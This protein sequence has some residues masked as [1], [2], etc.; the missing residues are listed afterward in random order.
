MIQIVTIENPFQPEFKNVKYVEYQ[1]GLFITDY[2]PEGAEDGAYAVNGAVIKEPAGFI[3][4]DNC[5]IVVTPH[6]AGG[7]F[8]KIFG[9]IAMVALS[10]YAG[11]VAG[12]LWSSL[13]SSFAAGGTGAMLAS[14]AIMLVGGL[15]ISSIMPKAQVPSLD[16]KDHETSQTYGWDIPTPTQAEGNIIGETYGE[17]IPKPQILTQHVETEGN[18]QYL[19]LLLCGGMGP[20]DEIS[21]IRIGNNDIANY[22]GV[23]IE[24]RLGENDQEPISFFNNTPIDHQVNLELGDYAITQTTQSKKANKIEITMS[25]P[26]GLYRL[27]DDGNYA[28]TT[29]TFS[30]LYRKHGTTAWIGANK[31]VSTSGT[32]SVSYS[33]EY[34]TRTKTYDSIRE[35]SF[36][37][38]APAETWTVTPIAHT[39]QV[40]YVVWSGRTRYRTE[41]YYT[42]SVRGSLSGTTDE[43][44]G[45]GVLYDNGRV[46]FRV[47]G[48]NT[49]TI[50]IYYSNLSYTAATNEALVKT[51]SVSG[52]E[53]AQY[54][55]K[56]QLISRDKSSR[57]STITRWSMLTTYDK[58]KYARPNKVLVGLRILATNQLAGGV[59]NVNWHQKRLKVYVWN[60]SSEEYDEKDARNPIWAAYDILHQCRRLRNINTGEYEFVADGVDKAR[61]V[62]YWEQWEEAAAYADELVPIPEQARSF[63]A[64][65]ITKDDVEMER[66]FQFD[67]FYDV[68]QKRIQAAQKAANSGHAAIISHGDDIGIIVDK[69]GEIRQIFGEGRTTVSSVQGTFTSIEERA[70]SVEITYNEMD[71]D[72]KNTKFT[73]RSQTW[74][75][76]NQD[77]TADLT[78]FGVARRS[79]AWREAVFTLATNERQ[80]QYVEF[81]AD[82]NAMV[83]E[84]GDI[85]GWNHSVSK[86]GKASGRIVSC[87][88]NTVKLDKEIEMV[89]GRNYQLMIQL[90]RNDSLVTKTIIGEDATTD[91]VTVS[92]AFTE[93]ELPEKYDNYAVGDEERAVKPFRIVNI[94]RTGDMTCK[95]KCAEYD[96]AIYADDIDFSKYPIIDYT[97]L[98]E[99]DEVDNLS[100]REE[101]YHQRDGSYVSNA[102]VSWTLGRGVVATM[103]IVSYAKQG[104]EFREVY[105]GNDTHY[106]I[107]GLQQLETYTV[108]VQI[109][110]DVIISRGMT[111]RVYITGKD[112][113]P[114][115]VLRFDVVQS[116]SLMVAIIDEVS[117]PDIDYYEIR[118]GPTWERGA[119]IGVFNGTKYEWQA[120]DEGT[121]TYWCKARDNSGNYSER[122]ARSIV[123]VVGLP[124]KNVIAEEAFD[125]DT[126]VTTNV[127]KTIDSYWRLRGLKV[128]GDYEKFADIFGGQA[129]YCSDGEILL[130]VI[131]LGENMI[132]QSCFWIDHEGKLHVRF[133][134]T[135]GDYER[136]SDMFG[137]GSAGLTYM[138]VEY[139]NST[140]LGVS[141]DGYIDGNAKWIVEYRTSIDGEDWSGWIPESITQFQ[142]R[143]IQVHVVPQSIDKLG[144]VYIRGITA[145]IDVPDIEEIIEAKGIEA[146]ASRHITFAHHFQSVKSAAAYTED[147]NGAQ[148]T[149]FMENL[150][151]AGVDISILD[152][153][154]TKIAGKLQKLIIRGY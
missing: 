125:D 113:A 70:K 27:T 42:Y 65:T 142:G 128:L 68:S 67:A 110:R 124:E 24:T 7:G 38:D 40:P 34:D 8:M 75:D 5:Q 54:D 35:V 72:F 99:W 36:Y 89:S 53:E 150:T 48:P 114:S 57:A 107:R 109:L 97:P 59:P 137:A 147:T 93:E 66:R 119:L 129:L 12:G 20:V 77:N 44:Q 33:D 61:F 132:D 134:T 111:A 10:L 121:I 26:G 73:V 151:T 100:V 108:K 148:A 94:S 30:F 120:T 122:A 45:E 29:V 123:N 154:G 64:G 115:D 83:S 131:D 49:A 91:T 87:E 13:G 52:L 117:D 62:K 14:G 88:G 51:W 15:L 140:F 56:V 17:C 145:K 32:Y 127:V 69:P 55:V 3:P 2:A 130:P 80:T 71:N 1:Q 116:G 135:I 79:Q 78:L 81:S 22:S 136:F 76:A 102:N 118:Q 92:E 85:I 104:D 11:S 19:N 82:I 4:P 139:A 9:V 31:A 6:V 47:Y 43:V 153:E 25:W 101:T 126:W 90:S 60:P 103:F 63:S 143:Y 138:K 28:N 41:T 133:T 105:R 16:Y 106:T 98:G 46:R 18:K 96:E 152:A 95:I 144:N 149:C 23:Q 141:V 84:Y 112:S 37:P 86:V 74:E 21:N 58:G 146:G 39:R 50:N